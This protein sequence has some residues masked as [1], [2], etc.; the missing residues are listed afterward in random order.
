MTINCKDKILNFDSPIVMGIL[1]LTPDS[2]Y[3]GNTLL[4]DKD[5]LLRVEKM[6]YEGATI[7]DIGGYSSKPGA[8]EVTTE[9]EIKRI[10]HP[11]K[12]ILDNFPDA[13]VSIDTFRSEVAQKAVELGASIVNDI[14]AGDDDDKMFETVKGLQVP[15]IIMH[16]KGIPANMQDAPQYQDVVNEVYKYL[17]NKISELNKLG[18]NDIIIDL[19]FGFGKTIPHNFKLLNQMRSFKTLNIPILAGLSRKSMIYKSLNSSPKEALNGT[20]ALNMIALENGANILRVHDV[21]EAV[22]CIKLF[23]LLI[24]Q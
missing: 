12:L 10:T 14:S 19:G 17:A 24:A 13:I 7:I 23:N 4:S 11:I 15:Y 16:K 1:N 2:F 5:I 21:K 8:K 22:E 18:V 9:E 3:D 6:L 20:T